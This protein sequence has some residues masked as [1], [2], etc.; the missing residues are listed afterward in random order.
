MIAPKE[1]LWIFRCL[2]YY[3]C[4]AV[5]VDLEWRLVVKAISAPLTT[6]SHITSTP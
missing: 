3:K 2:M 5:L 6:S 4:L 1:N